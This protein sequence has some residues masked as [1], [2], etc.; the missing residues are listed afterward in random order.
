MANALFSNPLA[1]EAALETMERVEYIEEKEAKATK[2]YNIIWLIC[3]L[4]N[5]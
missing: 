2:D 4:T 1:A 3:Q 5:T